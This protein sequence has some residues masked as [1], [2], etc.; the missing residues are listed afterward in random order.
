MED[1]LQ[2]VPGKLKKL[3]ADGYK[4]VFI[5]NQAGIAKGKLTVERFQTKMSKLLTRLGMP[6]TVFASISDVGVLQETK[7]WDLGVDGVE[8]KPRSRGG[9]R[10]IFLHSSLVS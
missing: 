9:P 3:V 4:L 2:C 10:K 6:T 8:R 5:T 1:T 7:D